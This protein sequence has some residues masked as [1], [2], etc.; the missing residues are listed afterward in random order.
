MLDRQVEPHRFALVAREDLYRHAVRYR[1]QKAECYLRFFVT[2]TRPPS[3][4]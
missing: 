3:P 4:S 2:A 1:S